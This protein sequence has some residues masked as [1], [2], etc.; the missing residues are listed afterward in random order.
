VRPITG[1]EFNSFVEIFGEM[2]GPLRSQIMKDRKQNFEDA[3][4]LKYVMRISDEKDVQKA[5]K[6]HGMDWSDFTDLFGNVLLAYFSI[7]S[8]TTKVGLI[9]EL[10]SYGLAMSEEQIPAEYR[11]LVGAVLKTDEGA[12]MANMALEYF[13]HVPEGNVAI[14]EAHK[15][16]LDKMFYTRFWKDEVGKTKKPD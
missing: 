11:D 10:A 13:L 3:D 15:I 5:L 7:Q 2:R 16:T 1:N 9:K 8:E 4:P 6:K 12:V 14:M